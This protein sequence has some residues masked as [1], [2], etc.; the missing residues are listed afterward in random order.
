MNIF[1]VNILSVGLS[2]RQQKQK[3]TKHGSKGGKEK[4][5]E[6][7]CV[8]GRKEKREKKRES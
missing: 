1:S 6:K 8:L 7:E 4:E 5:Q 2:V 3:C